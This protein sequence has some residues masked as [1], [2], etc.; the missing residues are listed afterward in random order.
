MQNNKPLRQIMPTV[1]AWIDQHRAVF[2]EADTNAAIRAGI[3]GQPT[4]YATENGQAIGTPR[5]TEKNATAAHRCKQC[6][7][8]ARPGM[9]SGYCAERTDQRPAYGTRHPLHRLPADNGA[10]CATYKDM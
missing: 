9:S 1:A 6:A 10:A 3:D 2:G 7:H 8:Y 5:T 4:F